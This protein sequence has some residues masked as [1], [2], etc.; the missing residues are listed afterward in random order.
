ML[1]F[2]DP[3]REVPLNDVVALEEMPV[4]VLVLDKTVAF[5]VAV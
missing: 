3:V 1:V 2:P 4:E 5:V